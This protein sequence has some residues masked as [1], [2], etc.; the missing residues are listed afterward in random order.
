[1]TSNNWQRS[2]GQQ[3]KQGSNEEWSGAGSPFGA[4]PKQHLLSMH[5]GRILV[6]QDVVCHHSDSWVGQGPGCER[7]ALRCCCQS[8]ALL[9]GCSVS[10]AWLA[11]PLALCLRTATPTSYWLAQD[12]A[13]VHR[14]LV[15]HITAR[16]KSGDLLGVICMLGI[17]CSRHA[18]C[19][20]KLV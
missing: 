20:C 10:K 4:V 17:I 11:H 19:C 18:D 5:S 8:W 9:Y 16:M 15:Y 6:C 3:A 1:M 13:P 2:G 7:V 14:R 12:A